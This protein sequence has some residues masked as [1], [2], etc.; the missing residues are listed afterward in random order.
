MRWR[1]IPIICSVIPRSL[2]SRFLGFH[3]FREYLDG[4][5]LFHMDMGL[6]RMR[7][8]LDALGLAAPSCLSTQVVGTNGK[9]STSAMLS[10]MLQAAGLTTGLYASPHFLS[11]KERILINGRQLPDADWL[12]AAEAVLDASE[13]K[14]PHLR[15]TYFEVL[16]VMAAWL[17][18][19]HGC[20]AAVFEAGLGGAHDAT[21]ALTHHL[22]VF[23]PIGLDHQHILGPTLDDIATDKAGAMDAGRGENSPTVTDLPPAVTGW[24]P[25][26][27]AAVLEREARKRGVALHRTEAILAAHGADWPTTPA[28]A[29]VHQS[30]NLGL[31]LAAYWLLASR[32]GLPV[33]PAALDLAARRAFV[34][35]R[36][37]FVSRPGA[38]AAFTS[39]AAQRDDNRH[40]TTGEAVPILLLDAAHNEPGLL[41]L[42][43][44]LDTLAIE[45]QAVIF[46]CLKDKDLDAM[47][48]LVRTLT[49]GPIFVPPIGAPGRSF[50]PAVLAQGIGPAARPVASMEEALAAVG[51]FPGVVLLCG[52]IYLLAQAFRLHPDWLERGCKGGVAPEEPVEEAR[53][54][55]F[56]PRNK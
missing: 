15:L 25:A 38:V 49:T 36:M 47:L 3:D 56:Q 29:G 42:R 1:G 46:A 28:M 54:G 37:Q 39:D 7:A 24:Q 30:G 22:T 44:A 6:G 5:G 9:G 31:A 45:P 23:T 14:G 32:H 10:E 27:A 12:A 4:L 50:D 55:L 17:F 53:P 41:A 18:R 40:S 33:S 19:E 21:T 48:P 52:S 26:E 8:A 13:A 11:P 2:I 34:P 20:R 16:T 43:Q 35:G 51:N